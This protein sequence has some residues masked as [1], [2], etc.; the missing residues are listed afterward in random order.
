[1]EDDVAFT[2]YIDIPKRYFSSS[3]ILD[4]KYNLLDNIDDMFEII[5]N[6]RYIREV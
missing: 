1:M 6:E 4:I 3:S 5:K 2:L